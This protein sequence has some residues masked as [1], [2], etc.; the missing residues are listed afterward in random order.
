MEIKS[1]GGEGILAPCGNTVSDALFLQGCFEL[2]HVV[3]HCDA[4]GYKYQES[5]KKK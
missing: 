3:S 2:Y 5:V 1:S 4:E